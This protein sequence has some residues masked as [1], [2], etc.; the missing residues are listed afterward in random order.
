M[1][2]GP[3]AWTKVPFSRAFAS[4]PRDAAIIAIGDD[5]TDE[6]LFRGLD[7]SAV[8]IKVGAKPTAARFRV[9][10]VTATLALLSRLRREVAPHEAPAGRNSA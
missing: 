7:K 10:D 8:T 6:D 9:A 1:K 5:A 3:A 4:A 2:S